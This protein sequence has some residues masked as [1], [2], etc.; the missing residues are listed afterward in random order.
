VQNTIEILSHERYAAKGRQASQRSTGKERT[1]LNF[2][3]AQMDAS[4]AKES[5]IKDAS[6]LLKLHKKVMDVAKQGQSF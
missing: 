2:L 6:S 1:H 5:Y 4:R 3:A